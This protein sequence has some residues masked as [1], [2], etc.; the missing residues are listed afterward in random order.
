MYIKALYKGGAILTFSPL[1]LARI[2]TRRGKFSESFGV[3]LVVWYSKS[4][5]GIESSVVRSIL[6]YFVFL[7]LFFVEEKKIEFL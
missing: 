5:T 4:E 7:D 3:V 6:I 2:E 1:P